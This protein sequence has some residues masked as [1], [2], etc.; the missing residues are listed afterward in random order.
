MVQWISDAVIWIQLRHLELTKNWFL[1]DSMGKKEMV[2]YLVGS[3]LPP[4][5]L[6][7]WW[8]RLLNLRSYLLRHYSAKHQIA[9][10]INP[11][12][13]DSGVDIDEDLGCSRLGSFPGHCSSHEGPVQVVWGTTI[14]GQ[15]DGDKIFPRGSNGHPTR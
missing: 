2:S 15:S 5:R 4:C 7:S 12:L 13:D 3:Q 6:A 9:S 14:D 10:S 8:S 11:S 1:H